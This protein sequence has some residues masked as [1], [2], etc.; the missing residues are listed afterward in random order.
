MSENVEVVVYTSPYCSYCNLMK[1][2]LIENEISYLEISVDNIV[3]V[4]LKNE[5]KSVPYTFI[6]KGNTIEKIRGFNKE[7]LKNALGLNAPIG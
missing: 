7:E 3:D 4:N 1:M 5:I 2:W 6:K